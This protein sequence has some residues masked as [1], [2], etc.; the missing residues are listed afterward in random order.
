MWRWRRRRQVA[1]C[2]LNAHADCDSYSRPD[3]ALAVRSC[4]SAH[5]ARA[6][7]RASKPEPG[8]C[9]TD[10]CSTSTGGS[11]ACSTDASGSGTDSNAPSQER[12]HA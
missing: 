7:E 1:C 12:Q 2:I 6:S 8:T 10:A 11:H 9:R 4:S 5:H 3:N